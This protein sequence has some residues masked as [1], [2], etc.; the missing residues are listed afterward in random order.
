MMKFKIQYFLWMLFTSVVVIFFSCS[1]S[2][3]NEH[4]KSGYEFKKIN[5]ISE[6]KSDPESPFYIPFDRYPLHRNPLPIGVFDSGTGGLTVLNA[7]IKMDLF[8]NRT[9][10]RGSDGIPDFISEKFI[11]LG[12]RA[13]MPYGRYD[14]EGK[15]D[16]LKELI[17]KD[18]QFLLRS[19]YYLSA[20]DESPLGKKLP[21]K[22]VVIACNTA[23]AYGFEMMQQ[24]MKEWGLNLKIIGIIGAGAKEA[25]NSY[26]L[27]QNGFISVFATEGTCESGEYP[28][29]VKKY[30]LEQNKGEMRVIQQ[31]CFGLAGAIDGD[32]AYISH[33]FSEV[34]GAEIYQGPG[35]GHPKFPIHLSLWEEYNFEQGES[36]LVRKDINGDIEEIEL[37]SIEN[38]IK[39]YVTTLVS[40]VMDGNE[41]GVI[42]SVI[43]GCTHYALFKQAFK[44]HFLYLRSFDKKYK[45]VIPEDIMIIDP[46]ESEAVDLYLYLNENSLFGRNKNQESQFFIS[47]PNPLLDINQID[48]RGEFPIDYKY[49]RS[50]NRSLLY[51]KRIPLQ[52]EMLSKDVVFQLKNNLPDLYKIMFRLD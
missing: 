42:H 25:V 14:A 16:F 26:D 36:L 20:K 19:R 11:Y 8:D 13:N 50:I 9:H 22:A 6:I 18:V 37:N 3:E 48:S 46:A 38:Y 7:I 43:L 52:E 21:V 41:D 31:P 33:D 44:E 2:I 5:L 28:K 27:N 29:A 12:D 23:T 32:P 51:V 45:A 1:S 34:R 35:L 4:K 24:V 40:K 30:F 49:G 10:E 17:I 39:Y 15:T 47:V